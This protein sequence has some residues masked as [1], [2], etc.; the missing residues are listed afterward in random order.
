M[1]LKG[2]YEIK[3]LYFDDCSYKFSLKNKEIRLS[4]RLYLFDEG[5]SICEKNFFEQEYGKYLCKESE[6]G[7]DVS[8]LI[9]LGL[10]KEVMIKEIKKSF[11][12]LKERYYQFIIAYVLELVRSNR[13]DN[14]IVNL[15]RQDFLCCSKISKV[16]RKLYKLLL[17]TTKSE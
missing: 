8:F 6:E 12:N 5:N 2:L 13:L 11:L 1:I 17:Y 3:G 10:S 9:K 15:N 16:I 7:Y 4:F 14:Y